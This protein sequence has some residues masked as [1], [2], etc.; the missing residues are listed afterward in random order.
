MS[1]DG[2]MVGAVALQDGPRRG[3]Q[4][5]MRRFAELGLQMTMLTGD[6][7]AVADSV[8]RQLGIDKVYAE[9]LPA[10]KVCEGCSQKITQGL[11]AIDD[12]QKV[13]PDVKT[14]RVHVVHDPN[15]TNEDTLRAT[16]RNLGYA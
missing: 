3:A 10:E 6:S 8:A 15:Q 11:M 1:M 2:A 4:Q 9:L 5:V 7:K 13:L 12:V 16:L 14:K